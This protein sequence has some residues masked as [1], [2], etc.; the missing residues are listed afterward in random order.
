MPNRPRWSHDNR[1]LISA[2]YGL[3][4]FLLSIFLLLATQPA[5]HKKAKVPPASSGPVRVIL[6]PFQVPADNKDLRWAA[7]A[8]PILMA[9]ESEKIPD[10]SVIPLWQTMPAAI[11]TAGASRLFTDETAASTVNWLGAKWSIWGEIAPLKNSTSLIV[12]FIPGKDNLVA[13]RYLKTRRMESY[14][15]AFHEAIR[16]FLRYLAASPIGPAKGDEPGLNS[17]KDLAEAIDREY[18]WFSDADPG[19]AQEIVANL[20][21]SDEALARLLFNPSV[22]PVLAQNKPQ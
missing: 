10:L 17:M 14:G 12:D 20:A 22:Y 18:G 9:K 5:C 11:A 21:K 19:K 3:P 6:L 15:P 2:H 7:L 1:I 13:F 16:Q 4:L 8:A